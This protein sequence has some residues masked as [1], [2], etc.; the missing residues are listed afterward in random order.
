[1]AFYSVEVTLLYDEGMIFFLLIIL[2]CLYFIILFARTLKYLGLLVQVHSQLVRFYARAER[3]WQSL[4]VIIHP[5]TGNGAGVWMTSCPE[6]MV[7]RIW[8]FWKDVTLEFNRWRPVLG[9]L[10]LRH[11]GEFFGSHPEEMNWDLKHHKMRRA[12]GWSHHS[13]VSIDF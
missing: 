6:E 8:R 4:F 5:Q 3:I 1:M 7:Q 11:V 13:M 10:P 2:R 12:L 9:L